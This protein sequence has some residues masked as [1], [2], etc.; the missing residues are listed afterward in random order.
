MLERSVERVYSPRM[1][2]RLD[3]VQEADREFWR[4][5]KS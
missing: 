4:L 1:L 5:R 3:G 2:T